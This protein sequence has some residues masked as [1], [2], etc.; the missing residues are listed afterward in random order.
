MVTE[1]VVGVG[2]VNHSTWESEKSR[3]GK[4]RMR[5][6]AWFL[7]CSVDLWGHVDSRESQS[8]HGPWPPGER[9]KELWGEYV[10]GY[11][12]RGSGAQAWPHCL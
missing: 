8:S 3:V 12:R 9:Q 1:A 11:A 6:W 4:R 2:D 10:C 7:H 5:F